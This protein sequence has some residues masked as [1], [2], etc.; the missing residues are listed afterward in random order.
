MICSLKSALLIVATLVAAGVLFFGGDFMSIADTVWQR[1]QNAAADALSL[2][3]QLDRAQNEL[4]KSATQIEDQ[5]LRVAELDVA[6]GDLE[7]EVDKLSVQLRE[8]KRAFIRLDDAYE[9]A[10]FGGRSTV[11][12]GVAVE[13]HD[14][15]EQRELTANRVK[16]TTRIAE[17]KTQLLQSRL[18]ALSQ[19]RAHLRRIS[20]RYQEI[21]LAVETGRIDLECMRLLEQSVG[22]DV[23]ASHLAAAETLTEEVSRQLRIHRIVLNANLNP[24]NVI[25]EGDLGNIELVEEVRAMVHSGTS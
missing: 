5:K 3:F 19:A 9:A 22:R 1:T 12:R 20:T 8:N 18:Q 10:E 7:R 13:A 17:L 16:E 4:A 11:Y 6:C 25:M 2:D 15:R 21:Q 23:D 24:A 14:I